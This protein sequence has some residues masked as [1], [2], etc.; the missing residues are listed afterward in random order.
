MASAFRLYGSVRRGLRK[1]TV[2]SAGL[3]AWEKAVPQLLPGC[4]TLQVLPVCH[5]CLSNCYLSG[6]NIYPKTFRDKFDQNPCYR[7]N[8]VPSKDMLP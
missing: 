8:Y 2:A 7:L 5:G 1:E 4:Q 6:K 3:S